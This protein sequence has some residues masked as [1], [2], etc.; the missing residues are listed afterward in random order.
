MLSLI[1]SVF[2]SVAAYLLLRE[3]FAAYLVSL[4]V[5]FLVALTISGEL[6]FTL[7]ILVVFSLGPYLTAHKKYGLVPLLFIISTVGYLLV[8]VLLQSA[9]ASLITFLSRLLQFMAYFLLVDNR[10][11][12]Q[13]LRNGISLIV[14]ATIAESLIGFYLIGNGSMAFNDS[15]NEI[16][17][18]SNSQPITGNIAIALLPLIGYLYFVSKP[19]KH[20]RFALLSCMFVLAFWVV[21]SGTRGYTLVYG[22]GA[23]LILANYFFGAKKSR[24]SMLFA[25]LLLSVGLLVCLAA[26]I[27]FQDQL[28]AKI[29]D[30]L[31]LS[32]SLGV[33]EHENSIAINFF[34]SGGCLQKLFGIGLGASWSEY[35]GYVLSV[36][37]EFGPSGYAAHYMGRAGTNFHNFYANILCLQGLFGLALIALVIVTI[38]KDIIRSFGRSGNRS[39]RMFLI[40]YVFMIMLMLFYR[41]SADCGICEF[42]MLAYVINLIR[43]DKSLSNL[44]ELRV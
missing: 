14:L 33:R 20:E 22:V 12:V 41:W 15:S 4:L 10:K 13:P 17:L 30:T 43:A 39:F 27:V 38:Q 36:L 31:R 6:D 2:G 35:P 24:N 28:I 19:D 16:R 21:L 40:V 18:V 1:I 29:D 11:A 8:G 32:E 42:A 9:T 34:S 7:P 3:R 26:V 44:R 25:V 23:T 5:V 37:S